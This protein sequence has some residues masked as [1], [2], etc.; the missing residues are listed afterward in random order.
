MSR[1]TMQDVADRAGV[2]RALVSLVFRGST[3][4]ADASRDA[5]LKAADELGYRP[6]AM[7]RGLA[8][9]RSQTIGVVLNDLH[10]PFFTDVL[11][12]IQ[13]E[14]DG[15]GY[16]VLL[17]NG[18]NRPAAEAAAV[19]LF[20]EYRPDGIVLIGPQ[21]SDEAIVAAAANTA[22][23]TIARIVD[24]E[25]I[26]S[27]TTDEMV[28][29]RLVIDHLVELG[30]RSIAHIDGGSGA[31]ARIRR[32]GYEHAMREH[33]LGDHIRTVSGNY[34][35]AGGEAGADQLLHDPVRPTAIFACND[36][37]AAGVVHVAQQLHID[38][39]HEL[40]IVGYDNSGLSGLGP[41]SLTTID[42]P[43]FALGSEAMRALIERVEGDRT[44]P[45]RVSM[46]PRLIV[47]RTTAAVMST[48]DA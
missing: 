7:A 40:S 16:R 18:S 42:Q 32:S 28:G 19:E 38:V 46:T 9:R 13:A 23:S 12:G 48:P 20:L 33:G 26:D 10:N 11:D 39:P 37:A 15:R 36:L 43:R 21:L 22:I 1:P 30:H 8:S 5:V 31:A 14:A 4:V 44:D 34:T 45:V 17:A 41:L 2:S 47:R 35:E 27:F 24:D 6:N 25:S 3:R 29:T